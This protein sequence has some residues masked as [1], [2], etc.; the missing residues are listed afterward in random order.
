MPAALTYKDSSN[1]FRHTTSSQHTQFLS[2]ENPR[3]I[4]T[5]LW[6]PLLDTSFREPRARPKIHSPDAVYQGFDIDASTPSIV[7]TLVKPFEDVEGIEVKP[8]DQLLLESFI[9]DVEAAGGLSMLE[10]FL[11]AQPVETGGIFHYWLDYLYDVYE[12]FFT[13]FRDF[14][15]LR[16]ACITGLLEKKTTTLSL[17]S[18]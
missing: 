16:H 2:S 7:D 13:D 14:K 5:K 9:D 11:N 10:S 15:A 12:K 4:T 8:N 18:A 1:L 6:E 3:S 17:S